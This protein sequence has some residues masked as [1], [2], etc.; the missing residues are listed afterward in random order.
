MLHHVSMTGSWDASLEKV[1]KNMTDATANIKCSLLH[2][3]LLGRVL[4]LVS[5]LLLQQL[6]MF[7][8]ILL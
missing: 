1:A 5:L 6:P 4:L 8:I 3:E 7:P 2:S